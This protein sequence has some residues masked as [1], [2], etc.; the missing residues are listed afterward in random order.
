MNWLFL[1]ICATVSFGLYNFLIKISSNKFN[2][3]IVVMM[4]TGM[5]FVVS[6]IFTLVLKLSG[7]RLN[8][9]KNLIYIPLLAGLFY[10]IA[11]VFYNLLFLRGVSVSVG[12]PITGAGT[13]V[14]ASLLGFIFLKEPIIVVKITGIL[15]VI[16]GIFLLS[17]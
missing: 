5:A 2:P 17:R 11:I 6:S 3:A 16:L 7:E 15:S 8:I 9:N 13:L 10:G 12:A 14:V 1:A 4:V